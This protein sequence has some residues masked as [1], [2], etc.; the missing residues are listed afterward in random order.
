MLS[1]PVDLLELSTTV[2][3]SASTATAS[4]DSIRTFNEALSTE[5]KK[6]DEKEVF[7]FRAF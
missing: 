7:F 6:V 4:S 1:V 2:A 3:Q 5:L